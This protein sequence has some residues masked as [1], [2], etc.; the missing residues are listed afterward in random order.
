[1]VS[2]ISCSSNLDKRLE[3][4]EKDY[5]IQLLSKFEVIQDDDISYNGFESD[6]EQIVTIQFEAPEFDSVKSQIESSAYFNQLAEFEDKS[7]ITIDKP[8][9]EHQT[10]IDS[11]KKIKQS[12]TWIIKN[13]QY[14]FLYFRDWMDYVEGNLDLSAKT[15]TWNHHHL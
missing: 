7:M 1:M 6:Y 9:P 2:F 15:L 14:V 4:I 13:E 8:S 10:I 3:Q 5:S 12:G 11:L